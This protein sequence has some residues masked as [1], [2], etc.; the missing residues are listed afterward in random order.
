MKQIELMKYEKKKVNLFLK[1]NFSYRGIVDR[2][3]EDCIDF[4]DIYNTYMTISLDNISMIIILNEKKEPTITPTPKENNAQMP[5]KSEEK[6]AKE[7]ATDKQ[8]N[9]LT[10][11]LEYKGDLNLSKLEARNLIEKLLQEREKEVYY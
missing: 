6:M 2:V 1:N 4:T 9:L 7:K 5:T 11:K 8:I 3:L 10:K